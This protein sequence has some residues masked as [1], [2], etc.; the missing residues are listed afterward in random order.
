MPS[1]PSHIAGHRGADE[2][3]NRPWFGPRERM[4][5]MAEEP[6]DDDVAAS[7]AEL[8]NLLLATSDIEDFLRELAA[9]AARRVTSGS[10]CGITLQPNGR[11]LTVASSDTLADQVDE[12]QYSIG[13]GPCLHAMRSGNWSVSA[14]PPVRPGGQGSRCGQPRTGSGQHCPSRWWPR[15]SRSGR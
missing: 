11:P 13:E 14:T 7:I 5:T 12:V 4:L 6:A 9:L 15:A 10:S 2:D 3:G 8:Q 1:P